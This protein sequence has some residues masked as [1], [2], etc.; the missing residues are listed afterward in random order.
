LDLGVIEV[1]NK[2]QGEFTSRDLRIL[3]V[4]AAQTGASIENA[5]IHGKLEEAY[6][7][8]KLLDKAKEKVINHLSHELKTPLALISG[9]FSSVSR[10]LG[11]ANFSA[12]EK[13]INRGQ[14][15]VDRLLDLQAKIDDI[16]NQRSVEENERTATF[17]EDAASFL[18][19]F[20]EGENSQYTDI[21]KHISKR[22]EFLSINK[23]IHMEKI[24]LNDFLDYIC[25]EATTLMNERDLNIIR[26]FEKGIHITMDKNILKKV[27]IGLLKNAIENT[28]D[29]GKIEVTIQS[30]D[31]EIR[32]D[33]HDYGVGITPQNQKMIFGGFFHTQDTH[34]YSSKRPYEFNAGG[35]GSDL[36][37]VKSFSERYGFSVNFDSTRCKF[38]LKDTDI[39]PGKIT[40]CPFITEKSGCFSSGGSIFWVTFPMENVIS[41]YTEK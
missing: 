36:L 4:L 12:L 20:K 29:E 2:K 24:M 30:E 35:S 27:F 1:I 32:I 33:I 31:N 28:P 34:L 37:R 10:K 5:K 15:N 39:C 41:G 40:L 23:E 8:L 11:K 19:E 3:E 6:E 22:M 38:I 26:N 18:E 7:D 13:T 9:V 16:L 21:L 14:R 17:I 25:N